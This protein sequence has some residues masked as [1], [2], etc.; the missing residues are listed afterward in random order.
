M[1]R[2]VCIAAVRAFMVANMQTCAFVGAG[3]PG[4]LELCVTTR[5]CLR[6]SDNQYISQTYVVLSCVLVIVLSP[7]EQLQL[8]GTH[9][10]TASSQGLAE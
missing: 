10:A 7:R 3:M 9:Q 1:L 8:A 2:A 4:V 6:C 5:H